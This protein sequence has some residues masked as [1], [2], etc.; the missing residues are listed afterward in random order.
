MTRY[1][2]KNCGYI[3]EP[4]KQRRGNIFISTILWSIYVLPGLIYSMWRRGA[5]KGC[6]KCKSRDLANINSTYGKLM[7]EEYYNIKIDEIAQKK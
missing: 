4:L 7:L 1:V 3:G 2:C 6:A 5:N